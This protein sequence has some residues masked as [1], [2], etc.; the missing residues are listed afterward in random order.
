[1]NKVILFI[2]FLL[3]VFILVWFFDRKRKQDMCPHE[4]QINIYPNGGMDKMTIC[5]DCNK[6]FDYCKNRFD[7]EST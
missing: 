4:K 6:Q 5:L 1:M 2:L 7:K 3:V